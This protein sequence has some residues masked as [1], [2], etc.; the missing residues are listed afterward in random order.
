[1]IELVKNSYDADASMV[2]LRFVGPLE[3][4][5]GSIEV[6]DNG[7]GMDVATLQDSWLDIAANNKQVQPLSAGRR[8]V[9]GEK[10]IGRLAASRLGKELLLTTRMRD[11]AEI[12]LLIDWTAFDKEGAYLDEIEVAW[13]VNEA[14]QFVPNERSLNSLEPLTRL[15]SMGHGT[16]LKIDKLEHGWGAEQFAELRTALTRLIRPQPR[17]AGVTAP[18]GSSK[19]TSTTSSPPVGNMPGNKVNTLGGFKIYLDL[20]DVPDSL[21]TFAGEIDVS[22]ALK[23]PH[24]TIS[25]SVSDSGLGQLKYVQQNPYREEVLSDAQLWSKKRPSQAGPFE[26]QIDVWDRDRSAI[27]Q[28]LSGNDSGASPGSTDLT[29]FRSTLDQVAGISIYRDG[30]RVLPFGEKGDDWL[31]L[32]L[33]RVQSPTRRISNN[34]VIGYVHITADGNPDLKDQSNREG[35]LE[36][37]SYTDLQDVVRTVLSELESRRYLARRSKKDS[38]K[39]PR[40]GLF[41]RFGLDELRSTLASSYPQDKRLITMLDE[42]S[43]D[44]DAGVSEMQN[45]LS[46]YSRLA[47]LGSL[48]DRVLHDGRTVVTRLKNLARFGRRDLEKD[49]LSKDEKLSLAQRSN[50]QLSTQAEILSSLFNQIEPFGGRKRGRPKELK[51][52]DLLERAA[53]ILQLEA[54]DLGVDIELE[55]EDITTRL[56]EAEALTVLVNLIQNAIYWASRS[57]AGTRRLVRASA[58]RNADS[59][60]TF[61]VSDSGPGVPDLAKN[62]IFDPYY[63]SKPNGIGLGLSIVGNIVEEIYEGE[64]VLTTDSPLQGATFEATFRKRAE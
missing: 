40:G 3:V 7:S 45:V 27:A 42:K 51:A 37:Q 22:P 55:G 36:G 59:S 11:S 63:S 9:L 38:P 60:I 52:K 29:D 46:R 32:D 23:T 14:H 64:L 28:L 8:R 12:N 58:K 21:G 4:G 31:G 57:P 10:G 25:G 20:S 18:P 16:L 1:M 62:Q 33:R 41:E 15:Q 61:S 35:F 17:Q 49:S 2:V 56:D 5:Q 19:A 48:V 43:R 54:D 6:W 13:E 34:Q 50:D 47:T 39:Q 44:I 53:A 24:Y 26:I 30:F